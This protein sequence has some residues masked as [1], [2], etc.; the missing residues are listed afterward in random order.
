MSTTLITVQKTKRE[1]FGKRAR[2]TNR[3][4]EAAR[5]GWEIELNLE[6]KDKQAFFLQYIEKY[7][8]M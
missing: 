4:K 3:T 5:G 1:H 2:D 8:C 7:V 6:G